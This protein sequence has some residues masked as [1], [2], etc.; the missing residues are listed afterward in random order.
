MDIFVIKRTAVLHFTVT[1]KP[2]AKGRSGTRVPAIP[3]GSCRLPRHNCENDA[4]CT[5]YSPAESVKIE[6]TSVAALVDDVH[7]R[8]RQ[9]SGR[10]EVFFFFAR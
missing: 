10:E 8:S 6:G 9:P 2:M 1:R 5:E 7:A 3:A 4:A